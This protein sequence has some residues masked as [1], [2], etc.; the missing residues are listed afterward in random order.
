MI[1]I[2]ITFFF[3]ITAGLIGYLNSGSLIGTLIWIGIILISILVHEFGH[4]L[5]AKFFGQR[6]RIELVAFGGLTYPEGPRL[7]KGKEFLV[8]LMGPVFGF[9]L[10]L[11]AT[12][13]LPYMPPKI[14]PIMQVIQWVNLF[15]TIVNLIPVL[16]LDGG[17]LVRVV[18]Q[19]IMG[20]KGLRAAI[21]SSAVISIIIALIGFTSGWYILGILFI[22]FAFQN[23]DTFRQ[24][25]HFTDADDKDD[26]QGE[27]DEIERL[28][29]Q[30]NLTDAEL[31]LTEFRKKV[32]SG[33]SYEAATQY[34][35][36]IKYQ[37]KEYDE[38]YTLLMEERKRLSIP[39]Q[40]ILQK[41]AYERG[42]YPLVVELA[43]TCYREIPSF[44]IALLA[45]KAHAQQSE[46]EPT[47]GWIKAAQKAGSVDLSDAAF[48]KIRQD[49]HFQ[50]I[51]ESSLG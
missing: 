6:P 1:P 9:G 5:T 32:T 40:I 4:A 37:K 10:F 11:L 21:I 45:A 2:R 7:S 8:I 26:V 16:P 19:G 35:A 20:A 38:A 48:D 27:L 31:R 14:F 42:N 25:R 17:Q 46:V 24:I 3:W 15:W 39:S 23:M 36:Q 43:D 18:L 13:L 28:I 22:L 41:L 12:I 34:L 49:A 47:L 29:M 51:S 33:I 44:E 30:N 50:S